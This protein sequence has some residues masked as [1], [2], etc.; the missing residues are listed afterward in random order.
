MTWNFQNNF[1]CA[2][3]KI[4]WMSVLLY[5]LWT[6]LQARCIKSLDI[7]NSH[8]KEVTAVF[9][10]IA[11]LL[12]L[13][14]VFEVKDP[15]TFNAQISKIHSTH[16]EQPFCHFPLLQILLLQNFYLWRNK[17]GDES[18]KVTRKEKSKDTMICL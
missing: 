3:L 4:K 8:R 7:G 1:L 2:L 5:N 12:S 13:R 14:N 10:A 18:L 9:P 11:Q 15:G 6:S 17:V 16:P